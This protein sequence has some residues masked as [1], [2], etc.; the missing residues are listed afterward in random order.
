MHISSICL[1]LHNKKGMGK[2]MNENLR[3]TPGVKADSE[4][5]KYRELFA[6]MFEKFLSD[7][8][9]HEEVQTP[10]S[11]PEEE[12]D[13]YQELFASMNEIYS[14]DSFNNEEVQTTTPVQKEYTIDLKASTFSDL[15]NFMFDATHPFEMQV[16]GKIEEVFHQLDRQKKRKVAFLFMHADFFL[17]TLEVLIERKQSGCCIRQAFWLAEAYR[18]YLIEGTLPD[19]SSVSFEQPLFG[20]AQQWMD[21]CGSLQDLYEGKPDNY[22]QHMFTLTA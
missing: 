20:T 4:N 2:G 5:D 6:P 14:S 11:E 8:S 1:H 19:L 21:L 13:H 22:I 16:S 9:T 15:Q 10:P 18:I 3:S 17:S 12:N 7:S